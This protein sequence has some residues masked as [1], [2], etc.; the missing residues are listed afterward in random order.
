MG[1]DEADKLGDKVGYDKGDK[2]GDKVRYDK[3]DKLG[4]K[5]GDKVLVTHLLSGKF[6]QRRFTAFF[7]IMF[8]LKVW[9]VPMAMFNH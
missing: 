9:G 2:L 1:Y 7:C 3:G 8:S 4:D 5:V 6:E